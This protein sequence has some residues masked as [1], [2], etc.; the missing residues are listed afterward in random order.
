MGMREVVWNVSG[1]TLGVLCGALPRSAHRR[2]AAVLPPA[3]S[4]ATAAAKD[5][6]S[7]WTACAF[8]WREAVVGVVL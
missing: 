6:A 5:D 8:R 7:S 1:V 4:R 2:D 3:V